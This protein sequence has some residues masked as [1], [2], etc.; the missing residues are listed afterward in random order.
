MDVHRGQQGIS[1]DQ[2]LEA[3]RCDLDIQ[4]DEGV[5]FKQAWADPIGGVIF[6]LSEAPSAKAVERI[7]KRAGNVTHEV[8]EVSI[9]L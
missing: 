7:H 5:T 8:H 2:L 1:A 4:D 3:H 6:C 9:E